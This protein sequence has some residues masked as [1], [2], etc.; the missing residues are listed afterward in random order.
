VRREDGD[1]DGTGAG[2]GVPAARETPVAELVPGDVI[3]LGPGDVVP[4]DVRLL[5]SSGLTV[6][7]AALTG[8]S[9]PVAKTA[10]DLP[11]EPGGGVL[12]QPQLCFLGSSVASGGATAVVT[13]TG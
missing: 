12:E 4:A 9:A 7:Q 10:D 2:A 13:A 11:P 3:R 6:H 5:R 8:E 1:D